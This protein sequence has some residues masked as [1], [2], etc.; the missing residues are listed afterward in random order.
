[1]KKSTKKV[2]KKVA[3]PKKSKLKFD[4]VKLVKESAD[5]AKGKIYVKVL[6]PEHW[7]ADD[8]PMKSQPC[9]IDYATFFKPDDSE[10]ASLGSGEAWIEFE[11]KKVISSIAPDNVS[12]DEFFGIS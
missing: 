2:T 3:K 12:Q 11:F 9:E 8:G 1:V 4:F 5:A 7:T 10:I 6:G